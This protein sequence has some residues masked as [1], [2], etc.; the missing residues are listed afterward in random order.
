MF[1]TFAYGPPGVGL[2]LLRVT[3]GTTLIF[4]GSVTPLEGAG[5]GSGAFEVGKILFGTLLLVGLWTPVAGSVVAIGAIWASLARPLS[6]T[7]C[8]FVGILGAALAL[9]GPGAWSLDA[10]IYGWKRIEISAPNRQDDRTE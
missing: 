8:I 4:G 7:P 5:S 3:A 1:S 9:L 10:R 6:L 2:L